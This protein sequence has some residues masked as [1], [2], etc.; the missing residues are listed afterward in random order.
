[1]IVRSPKPE[2]FTVLANDVV[3]DQRLSFKARGILIYLLSMPDNWRI[4]TQHLRKMA[5]EG[6]DSILSG[7]KELEHAG[8]LRRARRQDPITGRWGWE[9][10]IFDR[11]VDNPGDLSTTENGKSDSGKPGHIRNTIEEG[12]RDSSSTVTYYPGALC[13]GCAGN[14]VTI[15]SYDDVQLCNFCNGNGYLQ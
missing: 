1:M 7:L 9:Q 14:G 13:T 6:R 3:R 2:R 15:G 12:R 4:S 11:P 5:P 8:Y 10:T